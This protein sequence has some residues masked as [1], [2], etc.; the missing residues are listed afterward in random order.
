M[1]KIL[2]VAG[3]AS[4]DLHGSSL[5]LAL[6]SLAESRSRLGGTGHPLIRFFG[7]GGVRMQTAG[8]VLEEEPLTHHAGTGLDPLMNIVHFSRIFRKLVSSLRKERPDMVILIN[9]PDFNLRFARHAKE[10]KIPVVYYISPQIWAWRKGRIKT[11]QRYVDKMIVIFEFEKEIYQKNNVPVEFVGHPLLDILDVRQN[12]SQARGL[13]G[14]P[15][16][17]FIIGLLPGSRPSEFERHFSIMQKAV[18]MIHRRLTE[19]SGDEESVK[20]KYILGA[21]PDITSALVNK[22]LGKNP[23]AIMPFYD[24]TYEVITASDLLI[25]VSGTITIESAILGTPMVVIYKVPVLTELVFGPLIKTRY[26]AMVNII[27]QKEVVSELIQRDCRPSRIAQKVI[28]L[29]SGNNL[30]QVRDNLREVRQKLGSAGA[31]Y[32]AAEIIYKM[33][34][35]KL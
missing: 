34:D 18:E 17:G 1:K 21:A 2:V 26:Y 28:E 15:Q 6:K 29:I 25:T 5:V 9:F 20:I 13:L 16:D 23:P 10:Y 31:S 8:V 7:L 33:L 27:A 4:G 24:R 22:M 32:R 14:L 3:E 12:Q 30:S 35:T 11:I 19:P